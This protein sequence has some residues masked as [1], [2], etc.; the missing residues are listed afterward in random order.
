MQGFKRIG[1]YGVSGSGKTTI[2]KEV[3]KTTNK[4]IWLEGAALVLKAA[5]K[6]LDEFKKL[7][8]QEKQFF[9][10][11]AIENA[12]KI[13]SDTKK[14]IIIDGHLVFAKGESDFE[15]IM[16]ESDANFYTDYIYLKLPAQVVL[17]RIQKDPS[18]SRNYDLITIYRWIETE[19]QQL[20]DFCAQKD[21]PL[22][23]LSSED[24]NESV[25]F[26]CDLINSQKK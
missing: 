17:N 3:A 20:R 7:S 18:K 2:L 21:I 6:T 11:K 10:E 15:N 9:R 13:Q 4:S 24:L 16:T 14:H 26:V 19:L 1:L 8:L 25:K 22:H 12:W 23:I 5:N